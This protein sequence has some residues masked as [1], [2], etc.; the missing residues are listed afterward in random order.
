MR[1]SA[2]PQSSAVPLIVL[3]C[4]SRRSTFA[5]PHASGWGPHGNRHPANPL[6][7]CAKTL[8]WCS[9]QRVEFCATSQATDLSRFVRTYPGA[10]DDALA[11][12][13]IALPGAQK[14]DTEHRRCSLTPIVGDVLE[15][16]RS[17]VRECFADYR[18]I[19][20]TLYFCTRL[21]APNVLRYEPSSPDRPEWFHEHADAFNCP[22]ATRQVSVVAYLNDVAVGGETVFT[23]F[24]YAQR[25]EKGTLLFFPS[26]YLFHHLARPP[27]SG[28]KIVVVTWIHFGN[29]GKPTYLTVPLGMKRDR[30]FLLAEV[31]RN[32]TD[33]KTVFDLAHSYFDSD[34]FANARK[35]YARRA[36][37]G[38]SAEEVYYSLYRLAQAMA[39]LGEPWPD[40][41]DAF[42]QAW[43]FRPTRAEPLYQIAVHYRTEQQ[44]Q[45]GY[46]FA[47]RAAQLPLPDDDIHYDRDIY[48][49]R[50][51]DEQAV[52]AA[53]IGK[54]AEAFA[55]CRRLLASPEVPEER[56]RAIAL[57]RDFSAPTMIE[58]A[59]EYPDALSGSLIAGSREAEVTVSLVAGP[60][61]A[62]AELTLNSFL[63]C[64]TDLSRVGRFL[65]VDAGLSAQDR[66]TLQQRYGFLE[67]VD[68]GADDEAAARLGRLRNQIGGRF[69]LH[70]GQ[71]WRFFAPENY[72]TRL[73]AVLEAEPRVFQVGIN[74]GDAVKITHACAAEQQ[75]RRAPDAGRYVLADEMASGPAMF[76]AARL[77][78]AH[79]VDSTE[80]DRLQTASLDEVLCVIAT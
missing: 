55:L 4:N 72:I 28:P 17:V 2:S 10:I 20:T 39:N 36:E 50:A 46:L 51:I 79:N 66:A 23:A 53:W 49:W 47:E 22:S 19:S 70:L 77:D 76:D 3:V 35:W 8:G 80:S 59:A 62:A 63:H 43:A 15:R 33:A 12:D 13:L 38:G 69:W 25:C 45:L 11:A 32:P 5:A 57:N 73:C 37:L 30:D 75:V 41:Q 74:Y 52:C 67:F 31:E 1:C 9:F 7:L 42:L 54:H 34:D 58:A 78:Q 64:C 71:G 44:Y 29:D 61:R 27:E 40:T 56:R 16:F 65:V 24:D 6:N 48:T 60:D 21:E 26:N 14:M 68:P 18:G